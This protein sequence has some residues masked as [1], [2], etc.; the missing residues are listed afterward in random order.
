MRYWH[1]NEISKMGDTHL[2]NSL[3][4]ATRIGRNRKGEYHLDYKVAWLAKEIQDRGLALDEVFVKQYKNNNI[5][6]YVF[7]DKELAD[8]SKLP[9]LEL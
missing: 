7:K 8:V 9:K 2:T 4:F 1:G 5:V 3:S 6:W